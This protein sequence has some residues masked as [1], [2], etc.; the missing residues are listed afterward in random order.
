M[1]NPDHWLSVRQ[2]CG[3]L[4]L[5]RSRLYY[6]AQGKDEKALEHQ[7]ATLYQSYPMYGYRRMTAC[8]RRE[9]GNWTPKFGPQFLKNK[10]VF[11]ILFCCFCAYR[12]GG[13]LQ[14]SSIP[15]RAFPQSF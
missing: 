8:L 12:D 4:H 3:L 11:H 14:L 9:G 5:H 1:I 10:R 7:V 13:M 2:Q 15:I 6:K